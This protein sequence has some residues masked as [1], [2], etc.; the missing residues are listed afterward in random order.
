M[1]EKR[2]G[3]PNKLT[4][5]HGI[6]LRSPIAEGQIV[7]IQAPAMDATFLVIAA[8]DIV[9]N[10]RVQVFD[11]QLP[12]LAS[13]QV[14]YLGQPVLALFGHDVESVEL[15]AQEFRFTFRL[16]ANEGEEPQT[17][18]LAPQIVEPAWRDTDTTLTAA[19]H[20]AQNISP[21]IH[22]WGDVDELF[23]KEG[24]K[25]V[26]RTYLFRRM[27][28][29]TTSITHATAVATEDQIRISVPTQ[30][31]FHVRDTVCEAT[32]TPKK[33][34]TVTQ[35][36]YYAAYDEKLLEPSFLAALAALAS[37]KTNLPI[38][39]QSQHSV[40]SPEILIE[41]SSALDS[42]G[43][44]IAE[45]V[46]V[47]VD[48]GAYPLFSNE[49]GSQL[50]A[51][52][53]P[54]YPLQA[55]RIQITTFTSPMPPS[56]FF[57]DLGYSKAVACTE[58]HYSDLARESG[59]NPADWR[60]KNLEESAQQTAQIASLRFSRLKELLTSLCDASDYQRKHA[61]YSTKLPQ[62]YK[63]ST[64]L[65]YARGIGIA[66]GAGI[67]GFSN[68]FRYSQQFNIGVTLDAN[69]QTTINTSLPTSTSSSA[70]WKS[71]VS[72]SLGVD[73]TDINFVSDPMVLIDS[74]PAV[75]SRN[76]GRLPLLFEKACEQI[77]AQRFIEPL[78]ITSTVNAK[79]MASGSQFTSDSWAALVLELQMDTVSLRPVVNKVWA[80]FDF[81]YVHDKTALESK[82][83]NIIVRT[84]VENGAILCNSPQREF[85]M[86][87]QISSQSKGEP[88]SISSV[89][90]GLVMAALKDAIGQSLDGQ[91]P[92][93]PVTAEDI[94]ANIKGGEA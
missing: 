37:R 77:K 45:I 76:I 75:L 83:H 69:D 56:S 80:T 30:W 7:E 65:N 40:F 84:L 21:R 58:A 13:S 24:T 42:T 72:R 6:I 54:L 33:K 87:I 44:P 91:L 73:D 19:G 68:S 46:E 92:Y 36:P 15:K 66:C 27:S 43:K 64:F 1:A 51:G 28:S 12:L 16:P 89:L 53:V 47:S 9:G 93:L 70:V 71:I 88:I 63:L 38:E 62:L 31:P 55:M 82:I 3:T 90:H 85:T 81:G 39:M 5:F 49:L 10:N 17:V 25:V 14:T 8:R 41:R 52:L 50:I 67:S 11:T 59:M 26:K 48:Q 4:T 2:Q 23:A 60:F 94:L 79:A 57:G 20:A 22:Q 34:I 35:V 78:P 29:N 61:A 32:M 18:V 86:D 74:G